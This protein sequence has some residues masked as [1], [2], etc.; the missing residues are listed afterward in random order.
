MKAREK[1]ARDNRAKA[2]ARRKCADSRDVIEAT[3]EGA[4]NSR[5]S[6]RI[7][8]RRTM[9]AIESSTTGGRAVTV[10]GRSATVL[11]ASEVEVEPSTEER[12]GGQKA[13]RGN[14]YNRVP[15]GIT[16]AGNKRLAATVDIYRRGKMG[17]TSVSKPGCEIT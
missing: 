13:V 6:S 15:G 12:L 17:I 5:S 2:K 14:W 4:V 10:A 11:D 8:I 3:P 1:M 16:I 9:V 7:V